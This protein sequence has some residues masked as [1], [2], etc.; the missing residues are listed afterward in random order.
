MNYLHILLIFIIVSFSS[1][2]LFPKN[3]VIELP[4]CKAH[5]INFTHQNIKTF[6]NIRCEEAMSSCLIHENKA[7]TKCVFSYQKPLLKKQTCEF[8][9]HNFYGINL[10]TF[11]VTSMGLNTSLAKKHSCKLAK[12]NCQNFIKNHS[13]NNIQ[14][15]YYKSSCS[16]KSKVADV[17]MGGHNI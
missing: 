10:D 12:N 14:S 11:S 4:K 1:Q 15:K 13:K 8:T 9:I 7:K 2:N 5:L 16:K 3:I 6:K 17:A